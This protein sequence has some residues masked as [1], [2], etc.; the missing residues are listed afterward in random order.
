M[1][2]EALLVRDL[3]ADAGQGRDLPP[4]GDDA[5]LGLQPNCTPTVPESPE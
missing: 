2:V 1:L 3:S 4:T 5:A